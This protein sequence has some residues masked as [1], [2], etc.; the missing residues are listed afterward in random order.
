MELGR[1]ADAAALACGRLMG[2]GDQEEVRPSAAE[3][4]APSLL[5]VNMDANIVVVVGTPQPG[6]ELVGGARVGQ[7]QG[8]RVDLAA[9]PLDGVSLVTRGLTGAMAV[10]AATPLPPMRLPR[11]LRLETIPL[12]PLA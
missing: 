7:G 1:V 2:R 8:P 3:A 10:V 12:A 11:C 6:E 5:A 4:M 9:G